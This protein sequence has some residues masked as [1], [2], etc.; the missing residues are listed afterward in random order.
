MHHQPVGYGQLVAWGGRSEIADLIIAEEFRGRGIGTA[1][2]CSL[3]E[4]ARVHAVYPVEIG[5]AAANVRAIALY[6]RLGFHVFKRV[7]L[8][9]GNGLEP[10]IYLRSRVQLDRDI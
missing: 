9:L 10:V 3:L 6:R 7:V 8:D 5:A 2:I 4:T 1:L